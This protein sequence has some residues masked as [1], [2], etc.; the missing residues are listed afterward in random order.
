MSETFLERITAAT[1]HDLAE[2]M[3]RVPLDALRARAAEAPPPRDFTAALRPVAPD[4]PARL[5]AEI[6]RASPSKG[7][8]AADFDPVARARDYARGGAA[9]ISV[10]TEPHF[11][12]GALD[13]L[14]AVRAAV[15]VP[16]LRK[17]F[18]LDPIQVYEAR[19]AG[20][21]AVLLICALLDDRQLAAMLALTRSLGMA[22][23]V[24]AHD[25]AEARRAVA[26]GARII[27]VNSRDL[28]TFAVDPD[29][30]RNL[31]PLVPGDR[32]FVAE[33]GIASR[34]DAARARAWGADAI[35]V[36][37]ALMRRDDPES[38]ARELASAPGGAT[39]AL[40]A[41][42]PWPFVKLCGLREPGHARIAVAASADAFGMILA[43]FRR[44]VSPEQAA[45]IV[46]AERAPRP[47]PFH[48]RKRKTPYQPPPLPL[49]IGV[50]VNEAPATIAALA[51]Q[52]G[53]DAVQLSGDETPELCAAVAGLTR[54]PII[55]AIH[56]AAK[57]DLD[58]LDEYALAGATLLLEPAGSDQPGGNG[59]VGNWALAR[60][61]AAHWPVLLAG[62]LVRGIVPAAIT[63]V[64]PRGVDVS[65]G[66]ETD[67]AKDPAKLY[68]FVAVAHAA[69]HL[70][71]REFISAGA[72]RRSDV[73]Y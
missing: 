10:L 18:L 37:E 53:L 42:R 31:R 46:R 20:A 70:Y 45:E 65:S 59:R 39:A 67:G 6:K 5:I 22:A 69:S 13:H 55:K 64:A 21:D 35:L 23:L 14:T 15:D 11:F 73:D 54:L 63:F 36:G 57:S 41:G 51:E 68:G 4:G 1:R 16:V 50:F 38:L 52:I 25:A 26:A 40:F 8:L 27:G 3:A 48:H 47:I 62:G 9:A 30:V 19:A 66:T 71:R 34:V 28:R 72:A 2:R 12:Q 58:R 43:P 49:A 17:D 29:V 24:E 56:L 60:R 33:S 32:V 61:A 7:L 44:Q